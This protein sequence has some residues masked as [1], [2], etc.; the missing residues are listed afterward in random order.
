[1]FS[2]QHND[3]LKI[4]DCSKNGLHQKSDWCLL[5]CLPEL[6]FSIIISN[7]FQS[8]WNNGWPQGY[9][10][11]CPLFVLS[12]A[13]HKQYIITG[14]L[15]MVN[16]SVFLTII[17]YF[18]Y[19]IIYNFRDQYHSDQIRFNLIWISYWKIVKVNPQDINTLL[20]M[21]TLIY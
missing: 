4:F 8:P 1:M 18:D 6:I 11:F 5:A 21:R 14:W 9:H 2:D 12:L 10:S 20:I 7:I 3:R 16:G 13:H 17:I 15:G 19:T